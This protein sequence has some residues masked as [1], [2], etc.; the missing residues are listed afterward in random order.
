MDNKP[1][2][3]AWGTHEIH[4]PVLVE[5]DDVHKRY[6]ASLVINGQPDRSLYGEYRLDD[7]GI[8]SKQQIKF[9]IDDLQRKILKRLRGTAGK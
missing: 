6:C 4:L 2:E 5:A 1:K 7:S 8:D 3:S 9:A